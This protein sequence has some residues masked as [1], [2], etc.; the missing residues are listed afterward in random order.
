[1]NKKNIIKHE[2]KIPFVENRKE[3]NKGDIYPYDVNR[4]K[5]G[6]IYAGY[7]QEFPKE[8]YVYVVRSNYF[9]NK[10]SIGEIIS[11]EK[12]KTAFSNIDNFLKLGHLEKVLLTDLEQEQTESSAENSV[13]VL[14]TGGIKLLPKGIKPCHAH[15]H[16]DLTFNEFMA[17]IMDLGFGKLGINKPIADEV[18]DKVNEYLTNRG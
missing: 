11:Y 2:V 18:T 6:L 3:Y 7:I 16:I 8:D 14:S 4:P 17:L 5:Y 1:M 13:V 10:Y 12:S 15:K 9:K